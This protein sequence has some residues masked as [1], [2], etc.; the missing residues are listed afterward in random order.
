MMLVDEL[1]HEMFHM[2]REQ[3][4]I[5]LQSGEIPI[6][7]ICSAVW[8]VSAPDLPGFLLKFKHKGFV[9]KPFGEDNIMGFQLVRESLD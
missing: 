4:D 1:E 5:N 7:G 8:T 3:I 2:L 6:G 9:V